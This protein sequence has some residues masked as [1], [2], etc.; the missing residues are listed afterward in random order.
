MQTL[1]KQPAEELKRN[2]AFEGAA[3]I[4]SIVDVSAAKRNLVAGSAGLI[5]AG[6]LVGGMLFVTMGGG[7]DGERYLVTGRVEDAGGEIREAELELAVIDGQWVMPDGGVAYLS[8]SEFVAQIG[9]EEVVRLTDVAGDGRIDRALLV[10]TLAAVQAIADA[11][12]AARFAVPLAAVPAIVK[13][14]I[15]DMARA[16]L[17][18]RGAPEAVDGAGK[19]A[20]KLLERISEGKLPLP[21]VEAPAQAPSS[22]PVA[23]APGT[24]QYPD[25]LAGY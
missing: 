25:G 23:V 9:L 7:T 10:G 14:A 5:V 12:L 1:I 19:A 11:Y 16:R 18:T 21:G 15:G 2:L 8:I 6:E 17:Y 20:V 13:T 24:R 4:V 22:A 3:A